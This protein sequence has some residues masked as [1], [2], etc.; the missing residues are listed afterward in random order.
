MKTRSSRADQ[1][2]YWLQGTAVKTSAGALTSSRARAK[3]WLTSLHHWVPPVRIRCK[4][5]QQIGQGPFSKQPAKE[6][7]WDCLSIL[8]QNLPHTWRWR[9]SSPLEPPPSP[10]QGKTRRQAEIGQGPLS[11]Q[12]AVRTSLGLPI[13]SRT[14]PPQP[15]RRR[16]SSPVGYPPFS[17][18][19]KLQRQEKTGEGSLSRQPAAKTSL[20]LRLSSRT[21]AA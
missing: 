15:W 10:P 5:G 1:I 8:A 14:R 13:S 12:P 9:V 19:A 6:P 3:V 2:C 18:R 11:G 4:D 20:G 21:K 16:A 7:A 17:A